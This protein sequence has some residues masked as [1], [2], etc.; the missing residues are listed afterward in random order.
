MSLVHWFLVLWFSNTGR[1]EEFFLRKSV[2]E[3]F[4]NC[5]GTDFRKTTSG[6]FSMDFGSR[7]WDTIAVS[8]FFKTE[9]NDG[10]KKRDK[11]IESG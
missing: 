8:I 1:L 4:R 3:L 6:F 2:P 10:S 5:S 11:R 7:L 9:R